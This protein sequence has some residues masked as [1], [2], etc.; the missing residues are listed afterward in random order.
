MLTTNPTQVLEGRTLPNE[1]DNTT[2]RSVSLELWIPYVFITYSCKENSI[3]LSQ[4]SILWIEEDILAFCRH[5]RGETTRKITDISLLLPDEGKP[6]FARRWVPVSE[7]WSYP[8]SA[9]RGAYPIYISMQKEQ[10]GDTDQTM[11]KFTK[12][13]GKLLYRR[14]RPSKAAA[15]H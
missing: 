1:G 2:W 9:S 15:G 10:I 14:K 3:W 5:F 7:L 11:P 12:K 4:T 6:E 13:S 8:R